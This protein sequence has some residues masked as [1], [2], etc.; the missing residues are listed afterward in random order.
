MYRAIS[1]FILLARAPGPIS[2]VVLN[3]FTYAKQ[4][5][6][7][8]LSLAEDNHQTAVGSVKLQTFAQK[9]PKSQSVIQKSKRVYEEASNVVQ[10]LYFL[11]NLD[12]S[13]KVETFSHEWTTYPSSL[14][15]PDI[16]MLSGY[17][18]RRGNKAELVIGLKKHLGESWNEVDQL[19]T[20]DYQTHLIIDMMA[21]VQH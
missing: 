6:Q 4:I 16:N 1:G 3:R 10:H 13:A 5:G 8:A 15:E 20:S 18:M 12:N 2:G 11:Q 21:F 7:A 9:A 19:P 14:F 17:A